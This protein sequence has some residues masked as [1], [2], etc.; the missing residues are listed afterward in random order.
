M[1]SARA[2]LCLGWLGLSVAAAG[3]PQTPATRARQAPDAQTSARPGLSRD[4]IEALE[5]R[6]DRAIDRV[7]LPRPVALLGREAAHGYRLP[8]YGLV[9]VLTPRTLPGPTGLGRPHARQR[10]ELRHVRSGEPA[11]EAADDADALEHQVVVLQHET[12]Q[13]RRA[14]EEDMERIVQ[15]LR[16][17]LAVPGERQVHVEV[18]A[19]PDAP[20]AAPPPTVAAAPAPPTAPAPAVAAPSPPETPPPPPWKFWF[21]ET[22]PLDTRSAEAVVADVR[23]ALVET[24]EGEP[25][26]VPGLRPEDFVTVAVDFEE[27][28][29]FARRVRSE[30]TLL[31]RARV[32]DLEARAR[33]AIPAEELHRRVEVIEY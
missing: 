5:V 7:S 24:L 4:G 26:R 16:V 18:T 23:Q 14:A 6:L 3:S 19:A 15:D 31:V 30:R 21:Q 28:G 13:A 22:G 25:P 20:T 12:E 2:A 32:R 9:V 1:R 11:P 8:G 17:R 10:L 27:A 33:G 29:L